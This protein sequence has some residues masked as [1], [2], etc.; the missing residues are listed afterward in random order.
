LPLWRVAVTKEGGKV[1][2]DEHPST[3][4]LAGW[5]RAALGTGAHLL[6]MHLEESCGFT[7]RQCLHERL[8]GRQDHTTGKSLATTA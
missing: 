4:R 2:V 7:E 6:G 1:V 8:R 3:P 5:K